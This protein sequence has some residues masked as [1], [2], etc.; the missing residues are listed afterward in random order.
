M[1]QH[2]F[3]WQ[4]IYPLHLKMGW[5]WQTKCIEVTKVER[6]Q[7]G[8]FHVNSFLVGHQLQ[9]QCWRTIVRHYWLLKYEVGLRSWTCE[10]FL[11]PVQ[12]ILTWSD[13]KLK[14]V[15][16]WR[17]DG[18]LQGD[19]LVLWGLSW[20]DVKTR[21]SSNSFLSLDFGFTWFYRGL[22]RSNEVPDNLFTTVDVAV[23]IFMKYDELT[24]G[25]LCIDGSDY[26]M[27]WSNAAR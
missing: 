7:I 4:K 14:L 15:T 20:W 23:V 13:L 26:C 11:V 21:F 8:H 2:F 10:M 18:P 3:L 9:L 12:Q 1:L 6:G 25:K 19:Y 5:K 17:L 24:D 27:L 16:P 22:E